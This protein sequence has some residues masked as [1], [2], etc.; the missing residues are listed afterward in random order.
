MTVA[1]VWRMEI[2]EVAPVLV[3]LRDGG[4][5]L[6]RAL[7]PADHDRFLDAWERLSPTSRF[8]RFFS[9][10]PSMS[11]SQVSY[12]THADQH[13]HV[14]IAA[15]HLDDDGVELEG[16]GVARFFR[17]RDRPDAAEL[18]V[19]VIDEWQGRGIGDVLVDRL[20]ELALDREIVAL[21]GEVLDE[22]H[23]MRAV[24]NRLGARWTRGEPGAH[25]A[26]IVLR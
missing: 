15:V 17:L 24:F 12:F 7:V 21:T 4:A 5:V 20:V 13:D 25:H 11:E 26:E 19:A 14:A 10:M 9:P 1:T 18:A 16:V 6:V 2:D 8:R 23:A 22:N 3:E